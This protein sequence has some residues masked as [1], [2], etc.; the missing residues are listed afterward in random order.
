MIK[1]VHRM[2]E[3]AAWAELEAAPFVHL[4]STDDAG[5][6]VLRALHA[7]VVD[8][9]IAFHGSPSGDKRQCLG[10]EAVVMAERV[11]A[12]IPSYFVDPERAC[13]AS[14]YY[15][16]ALAE[17][18]L[19]EIVEPSRKA[20]VV[21]ALM[22][23]YQPEGGYTPVDAASPLY[24][25]AIQGV[26][27]TALVPRRVVGKQK[28]GQHRRPDQ[29]RQILTGLWQ[30]GAPADMA[31]IEAIRAANPPEAVPDFLRG[32]DGMSLHVALPDAQA[33]EVLPLLRGA[34]WHPD[35]TDAALMASHRG[36][37]AW[38]GARLPGS[39]ELVATARANTDGAT[40]AFIYDV[41][42]RRDLRGRGLGHRL[43]DLLLDHPRLRHV[44]RIGLATRDA[45]GFYASHGFAEQVRPS[46]TPMSRPRLT[47]RVPG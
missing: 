25:A 26:A 12:E 15:V 9:R 8:G 27:I 37:A 35:T 18:V 24:R 30:R 5:R 39:G 13:P 29:I 36:S 4:A 28:L 3:Q 41:V 16:S 19:E 33:H 6:P 22:R 38:V 31:A 44:A 1:H 14:T 23:R 46:S 17:G 2:S 34:Y 40:R 20:A 11:V 43:M 32:P 21:A 47:S 42:V 45:Q 7:V 10:R